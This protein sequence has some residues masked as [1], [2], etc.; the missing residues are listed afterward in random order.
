[1]KIA[2]LLPD[3]CTPPEE[4]TGTASLRGTQ[5]PGEQG[6]VGCMPGDD[7]HPLEE[8]HNPFLYLPPRRIKLMLRSGMMEPDKERQARKALALLQ[9]QQSDC[10]HEGGGFRPPHP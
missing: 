6:V 7:R 4:L 8:D 3:Y 2:D 9:V 10:T 1:M 5:E